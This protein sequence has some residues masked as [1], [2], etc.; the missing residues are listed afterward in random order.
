MFLSLITNNILHKKGKLV[1]I[2]NAT[3][4]YRQQL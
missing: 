4:Y 1:S 2:T 3:D